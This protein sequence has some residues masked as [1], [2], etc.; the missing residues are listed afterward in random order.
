MTGATE[1]ALGAVD[2]GTVDAG[3]VRLSRKGAVA[4]IVFDRPSARNAM[5][6]TMYSELAA[7][8]ATIAADPQIRVAVLRGAGGR[9]FVAGTDIA[10]FLAFREGQDG[11]VYEERVDHF[12][13]TLE[14][15]M[16]P[17]I[18]VIEGWA[19]GGGMALA[20]ACDFR[21]ATPGARF[22]VPIARTL[23][24]CLS[25]AN[26]RRLTA[27]LG[28]PMVRRM[29]MLAEM[30]TAEEMPAD[31]LRIVT[32][33]A[34]EEALGA[35]CQH[36]EGLAPI[37]LQVTKKLLLRLQTEAAPEDGDLIARTYGSADFRAGVAAFLGKGAPVWTGG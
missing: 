18:A 12:V 6:W 30:P 11:V 34:M 10:Q 29:L 1:A 25:A 33:E 16:V 28:L 5:T 36:L 19:V 14:R 2:P 20:N 22:G 31:W 7:H 9:A 8:C 24:N 4:H 3:T 26:L 15:L 35:L 13:S 21:L 32:P 27:G 17:T 37:T 23:G